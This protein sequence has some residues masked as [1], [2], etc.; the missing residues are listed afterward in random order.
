M[1]LTDATTAS[2]SLARVTFRL[3]TGLLPT[4]LMVIAKTVFPAV[5]L[6]RVIDWTL[7]WPVELRVLAV[8]KKML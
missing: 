8:L 2:G 5:S 1:V 3:L 7:S 4:F 6:T